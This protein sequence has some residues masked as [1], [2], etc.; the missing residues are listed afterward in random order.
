MSSPSTQTR[1]NS[2]PSGTR[3][4]AGKG[5]GPGSYDRK[6]T[7]GE[8]AKE[9]R[10]KLLRAAIDVIGEHGF[11][12]ASV[13]QIVDRAG[14]SRQ[15]FYQEFRDLPDALVQVYD[16]G[17][18][19]LFRAIEREVRSTTDPREKVE[20]AIRTYLLALS[21]EPNATLVVTREVLALGAEGVSRREAV[22][23]R[24][25]SL[26]MEGVAE[27]YAAGLVRRAPDET[28]AYC[29]V[30]GIDAISAR[31]MDHGEHE[32]LPELTSRIVAMVLDAFGHRAD[33]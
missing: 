18:R 24:Y 9:R 4:A 6:K 32:R 17:T 19:S 25:A 30:G 12:R 23:S 28:T 14:V 8:R 27:A 26:I 21:A 7:G 5:P 33:D 3:K 16:F 20:R 29:L 11:A 1:G 22:F 10:L 31:Y 15:A 13:Q 2:G